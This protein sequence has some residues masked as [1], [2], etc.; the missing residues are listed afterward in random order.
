[1]LTADL[2]RTRTRAGTIDIVRV[3]A[4]QAPEAEAL[5][6]RILAVTSGC[7]G[8]PRGELLEALSAIECGPKE[9][10]LRQGL[11]KLA[12]DA[13]TFSDAPEVDYPA[14]RSALFLAAADARKAGTFDR[15]ALLGAAELGDADLRG[16]LFGD[17]R[18]QAQLVEA[19]KLSARALVAS[20]DPA[21]E[22]ALLLR[23][24]KVQVRFAT[25]GPLGLR[26]LFRKL[27]F[28]RLLYR[29]RKEETGYVLEVD[30]P[31]S[32]FGASTKYGLALA[33][34]LPTLRATAAFELTAT[35][36]WKNHAR[37]T[38]HLAEAVAPRP[39]E[40]DVSDEVADLLS[41]LSRLGEGKP[42][43][44]EK[45]ADPWSFAVSSDVLELDP[46]ELI[47]PDILARRGETVVFVEVLGHWNRDAVF[48]RMELLAKGTSARIV[49]CAS[50]RLRVRESAITLP[51]AASLYVYK[52]SPSAREVFARIE[53]LAVATVPQLSD[54]SAGS[55]S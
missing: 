12:L 37:Y 19:P 16:A 41:G 25:L 50:D 7:V 40:A 9:V 28:L 8:C 34:L 33:I 54:L 23:A 47:V 43:K 27:K 2:V 10:K 46:T 44:R 39:P 1:V 48:R 14:R 22:Q 42:K 15:A 17:L 49:F 31:M 52:H 51:E 36:M 45:S 32:L 35:V 4:K 3:D 6:T 26:H 21:Q 20:Y 30:G 13:A 29:F 18:E 5:A 55:P 38:F 53:R 11:V 24:E